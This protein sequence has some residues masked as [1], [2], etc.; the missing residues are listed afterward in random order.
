[1]IK[2]LI[3]LINLIKKKLK[4]SKKCLGGERLPKIVVFTLPE[5]GG[6]V[7]KISIFN[8]LG[9]FV[10]PKSGLNLL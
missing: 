9:I 6:I 3:K 7:A 10:R 4:N 2:L 5:V 8:L 1:L